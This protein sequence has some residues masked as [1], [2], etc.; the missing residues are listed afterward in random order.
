MREHRLARWQSFPHNEGAAR[1]V[2]GI[3]HVCDVRG[4]AGF[5]IAAGLE[6]ARHPVVRFSRSAQVS[7]YQHQATAAV[8]VISVVELN[9][10]ELCVDVSYRTGP[11]R[12]ALRQQRIQTVRR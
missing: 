12:K 2:R 1:D 3:Q 6:E 10:T 8:V 7:E 4:L 9:P 11:S 5:E